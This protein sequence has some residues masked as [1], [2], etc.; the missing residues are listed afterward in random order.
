MHRHPSRVPV[1]FVALIL[2]WFLPGLAPDARAQ[3]GRGKGGRLPDAPSPTQSSQG[4]PPNSRYAGRYLVGDAAPDIDLRDQDDQRF[5]LSAARRE[6]PWLVVFARTPRD[7]VE[8]EHAYDGETALGVGVIAIAPFRR[9]RVAK[10]IPEPRVRLLTDGASIIARIYGVFDAVTSNPRPAVF[11]VDR[12]GHILWFI[13]GGIPES[14]ELTR[15]TREALEQ[16]GLR[17][18]APQPGLDE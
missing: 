7:L 11:L 9:V 8:A 10:L 2:V 16:A 1:L 15:L 14:D 12:A 4:P 18:P 3:G 6:K 17:E 13:A 5:R